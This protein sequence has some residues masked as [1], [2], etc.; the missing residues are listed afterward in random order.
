MG[1]I[2]NTENGRFEKSH[3]MK[4]TKLY[5]VWCSMKSRCFN[6]NHKSYPYYGGRGIFVCDEWKDNFIPFY[7]WSIQNGYKE[8]MTI[9]RIHNDKMYS[10]D[11]CRWV[12]HKEQNRNYSKNL[13][14]TYNGETLCLADMAD[15]YHVNRATA[16]LRL[17]NKKPLDVVFARKDFRYG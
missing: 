12:S 13:M 3:G 6:K 17:K 8:G 15:K 9:D 2:R 11:N 14:I 7:K 4:N 16:L 5:S 1:H 10:P